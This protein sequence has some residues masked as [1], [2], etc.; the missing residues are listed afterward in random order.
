MEATMDLNLVS[1][2]VRVVE[3]AS[4][5]AAARALA[6][7]TSS[8]SRRVSALEAELKV[9]LI[10]RSTRKL[11][12]TEAGRLYFERARVS[13]GGLADATA[14][15]ADMSHEAAGL[16]RFTSAPDNAGVLAGFIAEFL[17]RHPQIRIEMILTP[18]RVDL[19]AEGVDL[20]LRAGRLADSSLVARRI[21]GADLGLFAS[22]AYL[23]RMGTPKALPDLARHRFVLFGPPDTRGT[24]RVVGPHGEESV[25]VAGPI[26]V[27]DLAFGADAVAAGIGI[28]LVPSLLCEPPPGRRRLSARTSLVRVLPEYRAGGSDLHLVSPPTAYEPTRVALLRDFLAERYGELVRRC[29]NE[30][31][32]QGT[33]D[34]H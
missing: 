19:V 20:A 14:A 22:G 21:G 16:I 34:A 13:L 32:R 7:P 31:A 9:R 11:V 29:T 1:T 17:R 33:R 23:R 27:D 6:L 4:F 28:G 5:T 26:I 10:Q 12:L 24:L 15:V 3:S 18:R 30:R 2:F 8:V 25:A